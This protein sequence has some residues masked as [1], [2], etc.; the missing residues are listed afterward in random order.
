MEFFIEALDVLQKLVCMVGA[1]L[2]VVGMINF[3]QGQSGQSGAKKDEGLAQF[4]GG[5]A[6]FLIGL[7]L[8]PK[9]ASF[10]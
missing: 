9:L 7:T 4:M 1:A 5:G 6:I 3:A 10:F 2:A 8:V